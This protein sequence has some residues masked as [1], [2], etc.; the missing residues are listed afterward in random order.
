MHVAMAVPTCV[1]AVALA[2][3][4]ELA[5]MVERPLTSFAVAVEFA[6]AVAVAVAA[7]AA[8]AVMAVYIIPWN[9]RTFHFTTIANTHPIAHTCTHARKPKPK[10][11]PEPVPEL[12]QTL[13]SFE[14]VVGEHGE[15]AGCWYSI[16]EKPELLMLKKQLAT[17][18]CA[19]VRVVRLRI[20][21]AEYN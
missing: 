20:V 2:L 4:L 6:F 1:R 19:H 17:A 10:P 5:D 3:V 12:T 16:E 11:E 15:A 18:L 7:A 8:V 14:L 21:Q 13:C 9:L